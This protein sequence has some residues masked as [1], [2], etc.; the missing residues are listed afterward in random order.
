MKRLFITLFF[1][2][3][4]V[5]G[6]FARPVDVVTARRVADTYMEAM[7][8]KNT[9]SLND[10]TV[11]TPFTEFYVFASSEGGFVLV[12]ADDCV[13][14]VL[15]Y[16]V[17]G[18]FAVEKIPANVRSILDGYEREIR[19]RKRFDTPQGDRPD[20][21]VALQWEALTNGRMF[22][23]PLTTTV[24]PLLSTTWD[25]C[26]YYNILCPYDEN[27]DYSENY[28]IVTGCVATATAQIMKYHNYPA[29][30]HGSHSYYHDNGTVSYGTLSANFGATTYNWSNMPNSLSS[31]STTA[32]VNAVATLMYHI[33]VADEMEYDY[34]DN[35]G[36]GA[37]NYNYGLELVPC[38]QTSLAKY[39][40]YRPDM[41]VIERDSYS[42][43]DYCAILRSELNMQRPILYSGYGGGG[44]SFV[45]DG[46]N[47]NGQFHIN[48]GWGGVYDGYFTM[49]DLTPGGSGTGGN[50]THNYS[51]GNVAL[52]G[53]RPNNNWSA[54]ST[55]TVTLSTTGAS[56]ATA[57]VGGAGTY[58]FGDTVELGVSGV[59][60]GYR[61][62]G[63][64][65]GDKNNPRLLYANGGSYNFTAKMEQLA[66]DTLSYCGNYTTEVS[67]YSVDWADYRWGIRLPASALTAGH[68]LEAVQLYVPDA[69]TYTL[70]VYTGTSS[71]ATAAYTASLTF[72]DEDED[73]WQ[74]FTLS[75]PVTVTGSQNLWLTFTCSDA[76]YPAAITHSCGNSDGLLFGDDLTGYDSYTFLIR[77]IFGTSTSSDPCATPATVPYV[78]DFAA[79]DF[80]DKI[81][82]WTIYDYDGDGY[83]WELGSSYFVS[84]SWENSSA[85]DPDN[86]LIMP[87]IQ[88]PAGNS[89]IL[90][91]YDFTA[92]INYPDEH[93]GVYIS[94]TG[95]A[96]IDD[97]TMLV[98][99]T[100]EDT[101][102]TPRAIDLGAYAGQ[103][104]KLAFRHHNCPDRLA[105]AITDISVTLAPGYVV[106]ATANN[107]ALGFTVGSG[108][109]NSGDTATLWAVPYSGTM[110]MGWS[111]GTEDNPYSFIVNNDVNL[112]ANF[113]LSTN[114]TLWQH[115]TTTV[116]ILDTVTLYDTVINTEYVYDTVYTDPD[117]V[118]LYDTVNVTNT[119]YVYDTVVVTSIEYVHDTIYSD[120]DTITIIR[121]DT[122]I[123]NNFDTIWSFDTVTFTNTEYV[124]DTVTLTNTEYV[125]DTV[126][127][128]NTEYV[129]DTVTVTNTEYVHDT[130][131][132]TTTEYVHDTVT[133]TN[134]EY[135]Y[136]TVT[137]TNT[138]YVY[139]T[140][141][142]IDTVTLVQRDTIY[143]DTIVLTIHDTIHITDTVFIDTTQT[144]I[145]DIEV[146]SAKIYQ[147]DGCIVVEGAEGHNVYLYDAVG[148]MLA[149]KHDNIGEAIAYPIASSG[150][151]LVKVGDAPARRIAVIR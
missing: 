95:G 133:V 108:T 56:G 1:I 77:G 25:Q 63:W 114:D 145:G 88:L 13:V 109:Y 128:T 141:N 31:T 49:G 87:S 50:S 60:E 38:S 81:N 124:H 151:Y 117:T 40:K 92:N 69:G 61:F 107:T 84:Y 139:D 75:T 72:S 126:T 98:D 62:I 23:A 58:Q 20:N 64:T 130:V 100:L 110:F 8:M 67:S 68:N 22:T 39:F 44:H 6:V 116:V 78:L 131:T 147:R 115:D 59:S 136:D 137:V 144:G 3:L 34:A 53:I 10:V 71:P 21:A 15:G 33:G 111:N 51:Y 94:T 123:I 99:Y 105:M 83:N 146:N 29:T 24:T 5:V 134:T 119:E 16:S 138:E 4:A 54:T 91:W 106:S 86:W 103:V 35:G 76:D 11:Q 125:H 104:V 7:G 45:C 66:G 70:T 37:F 150:V 121:V 93:Y 149:V 132:L 127:V 112:V 26:P 140:V 73:Q 90:S 148:R 143:G 55:T 97:Y 142:I 122:V 102:W 42:D 80:D 52:I 19:H 65:D 74:T 82:C 41:A 18:R 14:P 129:Y 28:H 27:E 30:G 17:G 48:W 36:S 46:Y 32:Q 113:A 2:Q 89:S 79:D 120:A 118:T 9:A 135:V 101:V 12:S 43:E 47:N 85:L 96:S 57:T